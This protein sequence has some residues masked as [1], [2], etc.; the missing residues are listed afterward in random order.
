MGSHQRQRSRSA[1]GIEPHIREW[2]KWKGQG[3]VERERETEREREIGKKVYVDHGSNI[4]I[5][6]LNIPLALSLFC[7]C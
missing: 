3:N 7:T 6:F 2:K 1:A 5:G 4:E